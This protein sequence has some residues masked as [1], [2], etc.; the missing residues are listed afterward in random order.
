MATKT[1][2]APAPNP[3]VS[4]YAAPY[5]SAGPLI[6]GTSIT[7]NTVDVLAAK[8]F[9]IIEYNRTFNVGSRLRA[10]AVGFTDVFC[11][12]VVTAWDGQ[13]V[14]FTP[15]LAH[16]P[17]A[18]VYSNWSITVAGQPGIQGIQGP[19]GP[20][21]PSGGPVGPAGPPGAP[22]S[23]WRDG[24]GVPLNSLGAD[25]DY[26]LNDLT[27]D[28]YHRAASIYSIVSNIE[29]A[30]GAPGAPGAVGPTGPTG[31]QGIIADAPSDGSYYARRNAAWALT[32]GGGNVLISGTP[33]SG[34]LAQWSS[35]NTI[36]GVTVTYAPLLS[37]AFTGN[38]T[39]PTAST[40]DNS[41]TLA[42]TGF[43]KAQNYV[44][45]A[46]LASYQPLDADLTAIA[47]LTGINVIYYRSAAGTWTGITIG[48][49][50]TFSSGTLDAPLFSSSAK[51]EVPGSGGGTAN[52]LRADGTWAT[53]AAGVMIKFGGVFKFVS[54]TACSFTPFNGNYLALNGAQRIIPAAGIVGLGNTSVFVNGT[55]GQNLAA[56]TLYYVY[57]FDNGGT[58]TADFST[59][60]HS[61]SATPGN[62]GTEIKTGDDTRSLIGMIR[63]NASSQFASNLVLS[64]FNRKLVNSRTVG[65]TPLTVTATTSTEFSTAFRSPFLLWAGEIPTLRY[66]GSGYAN[67]T[68]NWAV[69]LRCDAA[70]INCGVAAVS[71]NNAWPSDASMATSP[72]GLTEGYHQLMIY[73]I[74]QAGGAYSV[75][76][77]DAAGFPVGGAGV[78]EAIVMG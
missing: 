37:P 43:V 51:G 33:T 72:T 45:T 55:A 18:T 11:E 78:L 17:S 76:I 46:A 60:A 77:N 41:T 26:Y 59:T 73:G 27:G 75:T 63:T 38:P 58:L 8:T 71:Q 14:T 47:A 16:N 22:G 19:V 42:T 10:T 35:G 15:D 36:T 49:G 56:N 39:A 67:G 48:A 7:P 74:A 64:W 12:G 9:T 34:Q 66:Q 20:T 54:T 30:A 69:E 28:V 44:T 52:F 65:T 13:V 3:T 61:T 40:A 23:V 5:A 62:I 1:V 6:A 50:L 29:G 24:S 25:G 2:I 68:L 70:A 4:V 31:P 32:P 53:P 21:G 57:C